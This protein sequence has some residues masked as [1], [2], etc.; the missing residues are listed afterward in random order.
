[1]YSRHRH[2]T[3]GQPEDD[4]ILL[5]DKPGQMLGQT[6]TRI[7]TINEHR[8]TCLPRLFAVP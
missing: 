4:H 3:S 6:Y 5:G 7:T 2:A 1:M 8:R